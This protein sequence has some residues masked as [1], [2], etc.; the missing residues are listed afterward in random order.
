MVALWLSLPEEKEQE[1]RLYA[2]LFFL[3]LFFLLTN[4]IEL[5]LKPSKDNPAESSDVWL[6]RGIKDC[7]WWAGIVAVAYF[8]ASLL[9]KI[10]LG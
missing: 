5:E 10:T 9:D 3:F 8:I 1:K 2:S 7:L 4:M 6:G